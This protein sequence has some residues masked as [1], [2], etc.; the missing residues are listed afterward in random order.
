MFHNEIIAGLKILQLSRHP[1]DRIDLKIGRSRKRAIIVKP[2][3][4]SS[5]FEISTANSASPSS[6]SSDSIICRWEGITLYVMDIHGFHLDCFSLGQLQGS[7]PLLPL[8]LRGSPESDRNQN[9]CQEEIPS[10]AG[11]ND[12]TM[13]TRS[14]SDSVTSGGRSGCLHRC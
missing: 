2:A 8:Y 1:S 6:S 13:V 4:T 12:D 14:S 10:W 7:H 9:L 11:R 3:V 5:C